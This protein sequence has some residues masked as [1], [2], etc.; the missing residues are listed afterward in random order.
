[1]EVS[2]SRAKSGEERFLRLLSK[3]D[4][5]EIMNEILIVDDE[6][7]VRYSFLRAFGKDYHIVTAETGEEA[8]SEIEK[9]SPELIFLDVRMPRMSG[10]E[11]LTRIKVDHPN[12]PVIL[13]TAY[14]D[15]DTAIEAMKL[16]AFDYVP[17]PF[18]NYEIKRLIEKGLE[19]HQ[20][21]KDTIVFQKEAVYREER[22]IGSSRAMHEI[23]KTIGRV[24]ESDTTVLI[25]GESGTGKELI[26]RPIHSHG[27]RKEKPFVAVNCAAIPES[28]L[29]SELFGYEKGAFSGADSRKTGKFEQ[30]STGTIF[31][32]EIGDMSLMTQS[33]ILRV[34]QDQ[35]FERLGGKETIKVDIRVLAATNQNLQKAVEERRFRGDLFYRLNVVTLYP[36]PLRERVED[37]P[38]LVEYF[39][40]RY[41]KDVPSSVRGIS[42]EVVR[43]FMSYSWPGNV[44]ELENV[45][46]KAFIMCKS[47]VLTREDFPLLRDLEPPSD[48]E[49]FEK[50][51]SVV[52]EIPFRITDQLKGAFHQKIIE[53]VER[54]LIEK[55]LK[56]V[57]N[58]Q[59]KAAELLGINRM[60]L[61]KR[62]KDFGLE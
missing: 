42:P 61:R 30:S 33:K 44:R 56:R 18:E 21:V 38:E 51:L 22:I 16:G 58:N 12:L 45:L 14:S 15:T 40:S 60:T 59:V 50:E 43:L 57:G 13:M 4:W 8:L 3:E 10:L 62:M 7:S 19:A 1:M 32:D 52:L 2:I 27:R 20:M 48:L 23:Y 46:K 34:L 55:T 17:K 54:H 29:E 28:L 37:I 47:A 49:R 35:S 39:I 53:S 24:A 6:E 26:A 5:K 25:Q 9:S 11:V 41:R 31:L 36:P